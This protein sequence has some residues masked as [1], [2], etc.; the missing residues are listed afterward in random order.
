MIDLTVIV[1]RVTRAR[2]TAAGNPMKVLWTDHGVY[3]TAPDTAAA[4][5]ISDYWLEKRVRI[6]LE[7]GEVIGADESPDPD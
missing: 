3:L 2:N 4:H 6:T 7:Y 1:H 5:A